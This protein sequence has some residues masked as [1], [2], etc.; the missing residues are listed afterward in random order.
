MLNISREYSHNLN[1]AVP[2]PH[3]FFSVLHQQTQLQLQW[4]LHW[5]WDLR[6]I[7]FGVL[8]CRLPICHK[9]SL[10]CSWSLRP[11]LPSPGGNT[12]RCRGHFIHCHCPSTAVIR[13][14]KCSICPRGENSG[15]LGNLKKWGEKGKNGEENGGETSKITVGKI[16]RVVVRG[17]TKLASDEW[18]CCGKYVLETKALSPSCA[19]S[20]NYT[21]P[22]P[23][24][25]FLIKWLQLHLSIRSSPLQRLDKGL[26]SVAC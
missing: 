18:Q 25:S 12:I 10:L 21:S 17:D 19:F 5:E 1:T 3:P 13:K 6:A 20:M 14:K 11:C 24:P 15:L 9:S 16:F 26:L 2:P 22:P 8:F 4:I 23:T 7:P